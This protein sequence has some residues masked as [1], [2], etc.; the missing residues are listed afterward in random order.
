MA[1]T[2]NDTIHEL[3]MAGVRTVDEICKALEERGIKVAR[4]GTH[5]ALALRNEVLMEGKELTGVN[6]TVRNKMIRDKRIKHPSEGPT[7][8]ARRLIDEDG[9]Y[10]RIEYV[11][12]VNKIDKKFEP[13]LVNTSTKD[14]MS[15]IDTLETLRALRKDLGTEAFDR[16][17]ELARA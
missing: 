10:C 12:Y 1:M 17:V 9:V 2:L 14:V 8:I 3:Y 15:T 11:S 13:V 6:A 5:I 7:E 4:R 16:L